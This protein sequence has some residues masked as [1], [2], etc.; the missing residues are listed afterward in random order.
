M[1]VQKLRCAKGKKTCYGNEKRY[2]GKQMKKRVF[3][4]FVLI[5][6][7]LLGG[8]I[9][10]AKP[11]DTIHKMEDAINAYD[12][13]ALVECFEP[14]VQKIYAGVLEVGSSFLGMD[15]ATLINAASGIADLFGVELTEGGMPTVDIVI[16]SQEELSDEEVKMN[17]TFTVN[18]AGETQSETMDVTLV[19]IKWKWYISAESDVIDY[20]QQ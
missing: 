5:F 9:P 4:I 7:V 20:L 16:N 3:L 8:C 2:G 10:I 17:L 11:E 19:L 12:M 18:Y 14:S 13:E 15:V 6:T 1:I